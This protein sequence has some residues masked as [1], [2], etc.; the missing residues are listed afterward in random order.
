M[1]SWK[2]NKN[3]LIQKNK[4]EIIGHHIL[5][6]NKQNFF[7]ESNSKNLEKY[8]YENSNLVAFIKIN[9]KI[10]QFSPVHR[11]MRHFK[12]VF[13]RIPVVVV[14]RYYI[15]SRNIHAGSGVMKTFSRARF[16]MEFTPRIAH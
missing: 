12:Y 1:R 6:Y 3:C 2:I 8:S 7:Q 13:T 15:D 5:N 14:N 16:S 11:N 9:R 4:V 10:C